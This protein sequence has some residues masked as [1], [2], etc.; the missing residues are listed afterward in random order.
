MSATCA[1]LVLDPTTHDL[2]ARAH[3]A[4]TFARR[5]HASLRAFVTAKGTDA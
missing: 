5:V 2:V 3:A 1:K 4:G